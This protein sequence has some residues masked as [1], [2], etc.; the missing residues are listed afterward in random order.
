MLKRTLSICLIAAGGLA[1]CGGEDRLS[2][3]EFSSQLTPKVERVMTQ[4]GTVFETLG[5]AEESD[6]VS[7][8]VRRQ[9][10]EAARVERAVADQIDALNPPE[11]AEP[12]TKELA[13]AAERQADQL[14]SLAAREDLTVKEMADAIEGGATL[15]ALAR[16][17]EL[18]YVRLPPR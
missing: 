17:Q 5:Q 14:R 9:L 13:V 7:A 3:Q 6:T 12:A 15:E 11:N 1:A 4:F 2:Q 8:D 10:A 18:G 16:L